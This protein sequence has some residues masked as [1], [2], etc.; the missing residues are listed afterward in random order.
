M[1]KK[2]AGSKAVTP[3]KVDISPAS[4]TSQSTSKRQRSGEDAATSTAKKVA[5]HATTGGG[6]DGSKDEEEEEL[7][8]EDPFGDEFDPEDIDAMNAEP[9]EDGDDDDGGMDAETGD[10]AASGSSTAATDAEGAAAPQETKVWRA[11][12]DELAEGDELEYDSTAYHMYHSLRPE[13]P[14]LS[15]DVIRDSLGANRSRY[16]HTVFAVAGTQADRADNNRLQVMKLSD[17]HRTGRKKQRGDGSD[18]DD[19]E[20]SDEEGEDETDD[21]PTLDHINIPHRGG[22]NRVRSMPQRPGVVATWSETSDVHVWDLQ[23]QVS[24]LAAK[25]APRKSKVDPAFTF[26]GHMEAS[27]TEGFALDW[28]PTEEGRLATGDC[29]NSVHVTRTVEGGWVTDPVPFVGHVASV[30]DLQ[31]SPTETTVFA[32][33]SADKTVAVWDLRKKNGAMLSLKA[34]EED[35]NVITWNRNVTYLLASGSDD[36]SFKIWDLRAF[37]SGEPVAQFRWHKAPITS[38]EWHPTDESMLA[39]SGADNQLTVWDLSVE[40]DDEAAAGMAGAGGGGAAGG[41]KDLPPQL[42]FIHQGQTDIK[43]LHFHPQIPG[44]IMSTAADGF[45]IFKPATTV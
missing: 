18:D 16:P 1:G 38:I 37:G 20:S 19:D 22:V 30:E 42:L 29:G 10:A 3:R 12:V 17:L 23:E 13:W 41:L 15:F 4:P 6:G 5:P 14:C 8:F 43:E 34:H 26:D 32:S 9:E 25:G 44:V 27:A 39:V 40:A 35:V 2:T 33:A 28:S 21:D 31:W 36:G 45:N 11:G 7:V 24:A